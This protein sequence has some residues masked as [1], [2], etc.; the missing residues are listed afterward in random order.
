MGAGEGSA[1]PPTDRIEA[2]GPEGL[3]ATTH[4]PPL[5]YYNAPQRAA[6]AAHDEGPH[7]NVGAFYVQG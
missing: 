1:H 6:H 7:L 3:L 4:P 5:V 2:F